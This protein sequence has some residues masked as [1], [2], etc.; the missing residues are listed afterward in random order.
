MNEN[1]PSPA[2]YGI[3]TEYSCMI[4]LPGDIVHEYVGQCHSVDAQLGLYQK[5]D[6]KGSDSIPA[7]ALD[8][9]LETMGIYRN[10]RGMLSNGGRLYIDPSGPEY[11]TPET[12]TAQEAVLRTFEGDK[13]LLGVFRQLREQGVVEGFQ[14]NRRIV[15]HNRTSRGIHLNTLTSISDK[16]PNDM[17]QEW[18]AAL[19]VAKGAMFGSGGLLVNKK[20]YTAF[21]HSPRLSITTDAAVNYGQYSRRPLVRIPFKD[22]VTGLGRIET[23][24]SDALNFAWPMRA[25]LV[26]TNA[27]VSLIEMDYKFNRLPRLANPIAAAYLVGRWGSN[28]TLKVYRENGTANIRP[29][30][31]L[32]RYCELALEADDREEHLDQE[33]EQVLNEVI[34]TADAMSKDVDSVAGRVES[35]ARKHAIEKRMEKDGLDIGSETICRFDYAWDWLGGGIAEMFRDKKSIGWHGFSELPSPAKTRKRL[36]TPPADT[37]AVVRGEAIRELKGTDKSTWEKID[38]GVKIRE[39]HP[40]QTVPDIMVK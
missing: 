20:G 31:L 27:L 15:D 26:V 25:S 10:G 35:V 3:E 13:I 22:D 7:T 34:E 38:N 21:H 4:T 14:L 11:C 33:S 9:A 24:T 1:R 30:R 18:L 17:V 6:K 16:R 5:P 23:V 37:R 12:T 39:Y 29:L 36:I 40:L 19:N 2:V 8:D 28:T 32:Q